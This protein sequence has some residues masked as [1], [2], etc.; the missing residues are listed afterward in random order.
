MRPSKISATRGEDTNYAPVSVAAAVVSPDDAAAPRTLTEMVSEV[1]A[2]AEN[3]QGGMFQNYSVRG[4][5]RQRVLTLVAGMRIVSERRAGVSASFVD[6][7]LMRSV[8]HR[9]F[10]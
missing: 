9:D 2:V 6:P 8:D 5:S 3:G 7:A 10:P 4:V 1:P